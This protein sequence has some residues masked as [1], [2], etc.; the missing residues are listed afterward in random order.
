MPTPPPSPAASDVPGLDGV[1]ARR[2]QTLAQ[3]AS[4]WLHEEVARRM[5]DRLQWF[6]HPPSSWLHWEPVRGGVQAHALLRERLEAARCL[7]RASDRAAAQSLLG[8]TTRE[9]PWWMP[10]RRRGP[11]A[12]VWDDGTEPSPAEDVNLVLLALWLVRPTKA[13]VA[14]RFRLGQ[15]AAAA[16]QAPS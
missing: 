1:A 16:E 8:G 13:H 6:R 7:L 2:W 11:P 5:L 9:G 10:R 12:A 4:P 14:Y 15:D 3:S